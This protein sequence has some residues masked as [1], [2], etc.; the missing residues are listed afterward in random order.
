MASLITPLFSKFLV[1]DVQKHFA[2]EGNSY[3]TLGRVT[4]T[5]ANASNVEVLT[6]N[7]NEKNNFY[8]NM[9]GAKKITAADMQPVVPRV[10]WTGNTVYDTYED[11]INIFSYDDYYQFGTVNANSN[12]VL[13]GTVNIAA[14]NVVVGNGTS[15]N[16]F[17]FP[18]DQII[19]NST[20]KTVVSVT[21]ADHLIVNSNFANTNTDSSIILKSNGTI[22]IGNSAN[23]IGNVETGNIIFVGE[24]SREVITVRSNKVLSLNSNLTVSL[25]N[26]EIYR[27]DNTYPYSANTFY[28]RNTRDQVFKCLFNNSRANS[29]VEPTIDIDGQLPENP[30]ILTGDGYKW[31]YLYTIAAGLKQ[32]FFTNKWMPVSNDAVVIESATSGRIDLIKVLWGGSGY[33]NGGNSNTAA[34]LEI[35]GTDGQ[36][37]NLVASVSNGVITAV[38]VLNGGNNYT[39]GEV[40]FTNSAEQLGAVIIGGTVN[41]TSTA[42]SSNVSNTAN[43]SFV[44]NVFVNDI[45]TVNAES[46]NVVTITNGTHLVVNTAFTNPANTQ[47]MTITRSNAVFDISF[48]PTGGHGSDPEE[49]LGIHSVMISVEF[50]DTENE[51]LPISDS[52]NLFDFNQVGIL[53]DP[54]VGNGAFT[55]YETNYRMT[56][57]LEVSD[58]GLNNFTDDE[59][60]YVGS[61]ISEATAVANV[62]H[63]DPGDNYLYINNI[64]GTFSGSQIVKG[65]TSGASVPILS[66]SNSE[67][68]L[69]TGELVY[70]E[71]RT[72]IIRKDNQIDQVKVVLSF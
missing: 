26:T 43:Q 66:I 14:S 13:S 72:N 56:T 2:E 39:R 55:A 23:F 63:W 36:G 6:W 16:T 33:I 29:T 4:G 1:D 10:D 30:F 60:V 35:T 47:S 17:I 7:T 3:I 21:N 48:P 41:I 53:L 27:K 54:L 50:E 5:G 37:A 8:R 45:V 22:V 18:S 44:G 24:E 51:T 68:K 25:S 61:S 34:I 31:K 15:F 65:V 9:L 71:N 64:T 11:H 28:V 42:I 70:M 12:T 69:F 52:T 57:R 40:T 32:R 46:R 19:V 20:I 67:I 58:P 59:T 38:T 62:A 49:E